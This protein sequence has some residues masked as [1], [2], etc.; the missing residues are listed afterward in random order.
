MDRGN[1]GLFAILV[2]TLVIAGG[3]MAFQSN[4]M[5]DTAEGDARASL[6]SDKTAG[7]H[8]G[9]YPTRKEVENALEQ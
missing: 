2:I 4:S 9:Q 1:K 3:R 7:R 8:V 5:T 6:F